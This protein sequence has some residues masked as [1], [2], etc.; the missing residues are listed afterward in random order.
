M[1]LLDPQVVDL[2]AQPVAA[3]SAVV[4]T[5]ELSGFFDTAYSRVFAA[6]QAQGIVPA[7]APYAFYRTMPTEVCDLDAGI[8]VT[9]LIGADGD[10]HP[11]VLP[12]GPAATGIHAGSYEQLGESWGE[13]M[14]WAGRRGLVPAGP[15]WEVYLTEPQPDMDPAELRTQ[16]VVPLRG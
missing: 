7:G 9:T 13:L 15:F 12:A 14:A 8:P 11:A 3:L 16:L 4:P 2:P 1:T 6:I 5:A 10:V